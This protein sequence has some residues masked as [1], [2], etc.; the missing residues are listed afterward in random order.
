MRCKLIYL[1]KHGRK[2]SAYY[3]N[4]HLGHSIAESIFIESMAGD[5]LVNFQVK[6]MSIHDMLAFSRSIS[7]PTET[8][9]TYML[10]N[11]KELGRMT[12]FLS[13]VTRAE[14]RELEVAM[15]V[16][17]TQKAKFLLFSNPEN[18]GTT[19][20]E[21]KKLRGD[22]KDGRNIKL[23]DFPQAL[24]D[25][26]AWAANPNNEEE[27]KKSY[28]KVLSLWKHKRE[29]GTDIHD[30]IERYVLERNKLIPDKEGWIDVEVAENNALGDMPYADDHRK[31]L[32]QI[33]K[34]L[35]GVGNGRDIKFEPE[36]VLWDEEL[37][38][39]GRIDLL[40]YDGEGRVW[41]FDYKTKETDT[42]WK[43][44][45]EGFAMPD[46]IS[47][48]HANKETDGA[49]QTSGYRLILERMGIQVVESKIL[50]IEADVVDDGDKY[51]Y[52][53]FN[54]KKDVILKYY[55]SQLG[56]VFMKTKG[57][58]INY[59]RK[60]EPGTMGN[61][62]DIMEYIAGEKSLMSGGSIESR[63]TR[64]LNKVHTSK[65]GKDFFFN[66]LKNRNEFYKS[67]SIEDRKAQLREYFKAL[68]D[69]DPIDKLADS[70][71]NFFNKDQ[72][73]WNTG[74][75]ES[76]QSDRDLSRAIQAR[77]VLSGITKETHTLEKVN[78]IYGFNEI[79]SNVFLAVSR[80]TGEAKIITIGVAK[81]K[82][83]LLN[84]DPKNYNSHNNFMGKFM[85][86]KSIN[87][88]YD[89]DG[90][91]ATTSSL[92]LI[93]G[94]ILAME[95]KKQG[96][97]KSVSSIVNGTISGYE[98]NTERPQSISMR[99]ILSNVKVLKDVAEKSN[100]L[101]SY[102]KDLFNDRDL[103]DPLKWKN[104]TIDELFTLINNGLTGL[105]APDAEELS[106][107]IRR[108]RGKMIRQE[109][110][111]KDLIQKRKL[112]ALSLVKVG[113]TREDTSRILSQHRDYVLL[114]RAILEYIGIELEIGDM[115]KKLSWDKNART[116]SRVA[117][118]AIAQLD[119]QL[120]ND[121]LNL[122][123]TFKNWNN[124]H[125]KLI[126]ALKDAHVGPL[127]TLFN[128]M[129]LTDATLNRTPET[130][131]NKLYDLFKLKD[132]SDKSLNV[133]Q[134][135]YIRFFNKSVKEGYISIT[136][137]KSRKGIEDGITWTE[138]DIPL[139][140]KSGRTQIEEEKNLLSK[141][142]LIL[143]DGVNRDVKN[144]EETFD[145]ISTHISSRFVSQLRDS[146]VSHGIADNRLLAMQLDANGDRMHGVEP[147]ELETHLEHIL[148]NFMKDAHR[149]VEFDTTVGAYNSLNMISYIEQNEFFNSTE[150]IRDFM[151]NYIKMFMLD[152][153][154]DEG[155]TGKNL[156]KAGSLVSKAAFG[157]SM[158]QPILEGATN[159]FAS[160]SAILSQ[161]IM[162]SQK[163]FN[164]KDWAEAGARII[165]DRSQGKTPKDGKVAEAIVDTWSLYGGD[166]NAL[167]STEFQEARKK[168]TLSKAGFYLNNLPFKMFRTQL[169]IA[170]FNHL[171]I[172]KALSVDEN[173]NLTY[174]ATKDKR[175]EGI[176]DAKGN[177][178][179]VL[180]D[181][182]LIKK[183][184]LY[185]LL[186]KELG[187]EGGLDENGKP[188]RPIFNAEAISMLDYSR[189]LLGSMDKDSHVMWQ[190]YAVGRQLIKFKSWGAA[191]ISNYWTS[192]EMSKT[193]GYSVWVKDDS[194]PDGGYHDF[195]KA[196]M[197]GIM[198]TLGILTRD[199]T[200][201][202]KNGSEDGRL[203]SVKE[204]F[205][206]LERRQ[207]ENLSR[208]TSDLIVLAILVGLKAA[209][210]DDEYWKKGEG[211]L[212]AKTLH[213]AA[214]D[215]NILQIASSMSSSSPFAT[216]GY[217]QR[218]AGALYSAV[219]Y[220]ATG[221]G[222]KGLERFAS[223]TGVTKGAYALYEE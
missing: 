65:E 167:G 41:V 181:D 170:E 195:Q 131:V 165:A 75:S 30:L 194:H 159:L 3:D 139:M 85:S 64:E 105:K 107:S 118:K 108:F 62:N 71:I 124:E 221:D 185:N 201:A 140:S 68:E 112:L 206:G 150:E 115:S 109:D 209:F 196:S 132:P 200:L 14:F 127:N 222:D 93:S 166:F 18:Y 61:V 152:E 203:S 15:K 82:G 133:A 89:I 178:K 120:K 157:F 19:E 53:N 72:K 26:E 34:F 126:R 106:N 164:I 147:K 162:G 4:L 20:S 9:N 8:R 189:S 177:V 66:T 213:N 117:N 129:Y 130:D 188:L 69:S 215:L 218:T 95:L 121:R 125:K 77:S 192:R 176:F 220:L 204:V 103:N 97:I 184:S 32:K 81:S 173:N 73:L 182:V 153:Y 197:E 57:K 58:D 88:N 193:V 113:G 2:A 79:P 17:V 92:R 29:A 142:K 27:F 21:L 35:H 210:F 219:G 1:D 80:T 141:I 7:L 169:F 23:K 122:T 70:F 101:S 42:D 94:G 212:V 145:A 33:E 25:A 172:M 39:A 44:D 111:V 186:V 13:E 50:Y 48:L 54:H 174:D 156:D 134:A 214:M 99:D 160:T 144:T 59:T 161:V 123:R 96:I 45:Q 87:S 67:K 40:A 198:Q 38:L 180:T 135:N 83:I 207:K 191:K 128:D 179:E 98:E 5:A 158:S 137:G 51:R 104:N 78:S 91:P 24:A 28:E 110:M 155:K 119:W 217:L 46:P 208:L 43:F 55:R 60:I 136:D 190:H 102:Y 10:P 154:K 168:L 6:K 146:G 216:I 149:I 223:I 183:R 211:K 187:K 205:T 49:L 52:T 114:T 143:K 84:E 47:E 116:L 90:L 11:G 16:S 199:I 12:E 86:N 138:G 22:Y 171:G 37:E 163:R 31:L 100:M 56:K 36:V 175:F 148:N 76:K 202:L 151:D 63:V 74:V